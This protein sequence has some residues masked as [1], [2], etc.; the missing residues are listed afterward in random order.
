[1]GFGTPN[2]GVRSRFLD[3]IRGTAAVLVVMSHARNFLI[4][5]NASASTH[6]LMAQLIYAA[7]ALGHE[8]V[9]VFFVLSGYL[10]GGKTALLFGADRFSW[11]R[12]LIERI[13][14]LWVVL[15]PALAI[16]GLINWGACSSAVESA[17]CAADQGLAVMAGNPPL[18]NQSVQALVGNVLFLQGIK[19]DAYG[20]NGPLW[21]LAYEFWYYLAFAAGCTV[22][23]LLKR[24]TGGL[25]IALA[26]SFVVVI[27]LVCP[28][29]FL[30]LGIFWLAGVAVR[31]WTLRLVSVDVG[32]FALTQAQAW[33]LV[34]VGVA[35]SK[36]LPSGVFASLPVLLA[37]CLAITVATRGGA[38]DS[39]LESAARVS[40][41]SYT[42]YV[43]HF[44][45]LGAL[46]AVSVST[47]TQRLQMDG[48]G[49]MLLTA[50]VALCCALAYLLAQAT[51]RHTS[52]IRSRLLRLFGA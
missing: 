19:V 49:V 10:V 37:T 35:S 40:A 39:L 1:M 42:L 9:L 6:S 47:T 38:A 34:I 51:E 27:L 12:F 16:T 20:A 41:Y 31:M 7:T 29:D 44:P 43:V 25:R 24:R 26:V 45:I 4:V 30:P 28:D 50:S 48:R 13:S 3:L 52:A 36:L 32:P 21:S 23:H 18:A 14:R 2:Q 8:A 11:P 17:Y 15:L 5:D 22:F 33:A 46:S